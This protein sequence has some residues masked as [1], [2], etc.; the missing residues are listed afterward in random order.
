MC[1]IDVLTGASQCR[2]AKWQPAIWP[3]S[4]DG[5]ARKN[6]ARVYA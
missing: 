5:N 6:A 3:Y 1:N 4:A 2:H